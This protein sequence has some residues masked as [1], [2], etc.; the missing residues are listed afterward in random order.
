MDAVSNI[1][2]L[3]FRCAVVVDAFSFKDAEKDQ[4]HG[5]Y[6]DWDIVRVAKKE[7]LVHVGGRA[8]FAVKHIVLR[9]E[10]DAASKIAYFGSTVLAYQDVIRFEVSV[11]DVHGMCVGQTFGYVSAEDDAVIVRQ[12]LLLQIVS[13]RAP[14]TVLDD[15]MVATILLHEI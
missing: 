11:H 10:L 4:S 8:Y 14:R 1:L 13:Q 5:I 12:H 6:I 15:D 7:S 3:W 2:N 9:L